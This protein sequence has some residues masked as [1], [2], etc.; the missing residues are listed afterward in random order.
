MSVKDTIS[1]KIQAAIEGYDFDEAIE[2]AIE[3]IDI[4]ELITDRLER[5]IARIDME[6]LLTDLIGDY[7]DNELDEMSIED[8]VLRAV[9][10]AFEDL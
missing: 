1:R 4:E 2:E 7:I 9:Q 3:N 5:K 10:D 8:D 6:P